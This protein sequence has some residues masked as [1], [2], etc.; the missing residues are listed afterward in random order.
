MKRARTFRLD[1]D[2]LDPALK[3][4]GHAGDEPAAA[5]RDE[6]RVELLEPESFEVLL[7]LERNRPLARD[8]LDRI[9]RMDQE[10]AA[11]GDI[12]VAPLLRLA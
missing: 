11:L 1:A 8:R 7:P 12:G 5:N 3:P 10:S 4:G 6:N 2:D 9:V